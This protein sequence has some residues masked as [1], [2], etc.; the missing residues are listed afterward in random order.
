[1]ILA[2]HLTRTHGVVYMKI[3]EFIECSMIRRRVGLKYLEPSLHMSVIDHCL[4]H[5]L[6]HQID[7]PLKQLCTEIQIVHSFRSQVLWGSNAWDPKLNKLSI[8][9]MNRASIPICECAESLCPDI[10]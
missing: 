8:H 2:M 4:G 1:M 6:A 3:F 7:D 10:L 5:L 9:H